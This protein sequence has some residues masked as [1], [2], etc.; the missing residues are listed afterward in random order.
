MLNPVNLL[1]VFSIKFTNHN[2]EYMQQ[3]A[4][5]HIHTYYSDSTSSPLEVVEYARKEGLNCIAITD[6]DTVE[7]IK[8][9]IEAAKKYDIE[10]ISGIELSASVNSRDVHILGY[11]FDYNDNELVRHLNKI[12]EFRLGRMRKMI[13]KL[14]QLGIDEIE[15]KDVA[16]LAH[17]N[18]LG[19]PHLAQVLVNK[20]IVSNIKSAFDKYLGDGAPACVEHFKQTPKE[21]IDLIHKYGGVAVLAH[22]MLTRVDELIAQFTKDGLDGLEAYYP[23]NSKQITE[24]YCGLAR[25]YNLFPTG[26]SDAHGDAKKHTFVGKMKIP[27]ELVECMKS[28]CFQ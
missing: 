1:M 22:P 4:D 25:K 7:G 24:F 17:S 11:M 14:A 5:L 2:K 18:S 20:G 8:P 28:A 16:E 15:F 27:Y 19:R 12:Q 26:G 3:F 6:H 21:A 13:D 23:N 10:V 9:A